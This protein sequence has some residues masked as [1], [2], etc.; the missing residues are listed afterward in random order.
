MAR[1][2]TVTGRQ[3]LAGPRPSRLLGA[4]ALAASLLISLAPSALAAAP[5]NDDR[6]AAIPIAL[7]GSASTDLTEATRA[8]DDPPP[9][10]PGSTE[11]GS[12]WYSYTALEAG[13][14]RIAFED[15]LG[16]AAVHLLDTGGAQL[17][18]DV[19]PARVRAEVG[20]V[21]YVLFDAA[22]G[23]TYLIELTTVSPTPPWSASISIV[24]SIDDVAL[25]SVSDGRLDGDGNAVFE[26]GFTCRAGTGYFEVLIDVAQRRRSETVGAAGNN[27][28]ANCTDAVILVEVVAASGWREVGAQMRTYDESLRLVAGPASMRIDWH[29]AMIAADKRGV[30]TRTVQLLGG[31]GGPSATLP[32]T[33]GGGRAI[34]SGGAGPVGLLVGFLVLV[35]LAV[36]LV[37]SP[38]PRRPGA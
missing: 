37:A 15:S 38:R 31:T 2:P 34:G 22:V 26:L 35:G 8:P 12:V 17:D 21:D 13:P 19:Q 5:A 28:A 14:T 23:A 30:E 29:F 32:P 36:L 1:G 6:S 7:F 9:C 11:Y 27:S 20:Q 25:V 18:C 16:A 33:D 24:S 10:I 4:V 3:H